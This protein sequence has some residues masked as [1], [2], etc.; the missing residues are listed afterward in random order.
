MLTGTVTVR[1]AQ[2]TRRFEATPDILSLATGEKGPLGAPAAPSAVPLRLDIH[3]LAPGTLRI[4]NNLARVRASADLRLGGTYDRPQLFGRADIIRGDLLFEGNRYVVTRGSVDFSNPLRIDPY[5]DIE[6]ETRV[7]VPGS[8]GGGSSQI[9]RVT[10]GV[11]GTATQ[12]TP[13]INSDPPLPEIDI[14]SLLL[15][16]TTD[17]DA[18]LRLRNPATASQTET[19]LL[20]ALTSRLIASPISSP[21]G[22]VVEQTLGFDTVQITPSIGTESDPLNPSARLII[23]KRI[24]N[25][26]YLTF[27]RALG[28]RRARPDHHGRIRSERQSGTGDHADRQQHL[29]DRLPRAAHLLNG[30]P[31]GDSAPALGP[32]AAPWRAEAPEAR[33]RQESSAVSRFVGKPI[34][35]TEVVVESFRTDDAMVRDLIETRAGEML[36]MADV[37]ET[38]AHLF[39]LGR[40]QDIQVEAFA[41]GNGIRVRYNLIPIHSVQRVRFRGELGLSEGTLRNA[42]TE[43]FGPT[44]SA[45]RATEVAQRLQEVYNERGY[46]AAAV[47]PVVE[48]VHDPDQTI[49]TFE[50][51]SGPVAR[52]G[53]VNVEGDPGEPRDPFLRRIHAEPGRIYERIDVD[54]RLGD[55]VQRQRKQG[56]YEATARHTFRQSDDGKTVT[57]N[58]DVDRGPLVTVQFTGDPLPKDRLDELVPVQREGSVDADLIEDSERRIV[59]FLNEQGYWKAA[60]TS[61]RQQTEQRLDIVFNIRR[62]LQYRIEDGVEVT[63]N[64]AITM[65]E[66]R[67]VLVR[68]GA[69]ELFVESNLG[70][71]VAAIRG[72]YLRRGFAQLKIAADA[73]ERNPAAGGEGRVKP[74][75]TITEGPLTLVGAVAFAGNQAVSSAELAAR[76]GSATGRPYFEPTVVQD[77]DALILEYRNRGFAAAAVEVAAQLAEDKSS[78]AQPFRAVDLTFKISEGPQTIVDHILIVGNVRTDPKV[79]QREIVL[80]P[81][82][83]LGLTDLIESRRRVAA[84]GLF[85]RVRVHRDYAQRFDQARPAGDGRGSPFDVCRLRRRSGSEPEAAAGRHRCGR[86]AARV[87]P[88]RLLRD[89]PTQHR[90][91]QPLG[92]PLHAA[93]PP[94]RFERGERHQRRQ[95]VWLR[96]VPRHRH[97][98]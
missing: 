82:Q 29:R 36:S 77:R 30:L 63:G 71:A 47:R 45:N 24:S 10:I 7:R 52:I 96:G 14:V 1:D 92:Q 81:G 19:E 32:P 60:V 85:R 18:D 25:R 28:V 38:I 27:A 39:S 57:L 80:Q 16:Q 83:P 76:I 53:Q 58:V 31:A 65:E 4:E 15:G 35:A 22:R 98:P 88:S 97:L 13:T 5:V 91:T 61:T 64:Q 46:L 78:V 34:V 41:E 93:Q 66:L 3:V 79:I 44:P 20:R 9:Y 94:P 69:G 42:V 33:R 84:L 70:A 59:S 75:I 90:W 72:I 74:S 48:V 17:L 56:R 12:F 95:H 6:A 51:N 68:L 11:T 89:R 2:W 37:R 86:G 8:L 43:R 23:G 21:V 50:I 49:L 73:N 62:G 55:F 67:P 54:E 40:Y 87:R 26:A